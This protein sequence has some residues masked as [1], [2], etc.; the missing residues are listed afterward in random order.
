MVTALRHRGP[1]ETHVVDLGDAIFGHARL[2]VIDLETGTQPMST[3]DGRLWITYNGEIYNYVEIREELRNRGHVFRTESDT[4][5]VLASYLEW[6]GQCFSRLN[7]QWSLALWDRNSGS[8]LLSRDPFGIQPLYYTVY[9]GAVLFASE[10]KALFTHREIRRSLDPHGLAQ[11]FTFWCPLAPQTAFRD[12]YSLEPGCSLPVPSDRGRLSAT[13]LRPSR[14]F[15][16]SYGT[17]DRV[18]RASL[19]ENVDRF[20]AAFTDACRLRFRRS[21]VPVG[22]YLSGGID[23][24]VTTAVIASATPSPI[25]T[26]SVSFT[27]SEFDE[28]NYQRCVSDHLGTTHN[29]IRISAGDIGKVFPEVIRHA[30]QPILRTAPAPLFILSQLVHEK[31]YKVVV[32][33]EGS[34]EML[35]GYDIF[36]EAA[37]RR[38]VA[39]RPDSIACRGLLLQLYPWLRRSPSRVPAFA[40][41]FFARSE[42]LKDP[43]FSHRPRWS[44]TSALLRMLNSDFGAPDAGVVEEEFLSEMPLE[45]ERWHPLEQ[46]QYLEFH[47]ILSNYLLSAQG[48]R[49]LAAHSVEGRFPFLDPN[50]VRLAASLPPR[51]KLMG[52]REKYILKSAFSHLIPTEITDRPKQPYRAPDA[53]AF[54]ADGTSPE[55]FEEL[56]SPAAIT[57]A[58][59][60]NAAAVSA[61][62]K[63]CR[64][65]DGIGMSNTDNMRLVALASTMLLHEILV[66]DNTGACG[67]NGDRDI[68][69][70]RNA[71]STN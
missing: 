41:A 67:S 60:F 20:R 68:P 59:I 30:E 8:A 29:P 24:A 34:D 14:H 50:I 36:R 51:H 65:K 10:V 37:V 49:M 66:K 2:A 9:H 23:S 46:A 5:V 27:D 22:A 19:T 25:Q 61:L 53:R 18:R 7:G 12:V 15:V 16:V 71:L 28:S 35:A 3:P 58:G 32:T 43:A 54:V 31:G 63:K 11:A 13:M 48:D 17:D 52:L 6:G 38:L 40:Q 56:T 62:I 44:A 69:I 26:F 70:R 39:R 1:D 45:F 47:T 21:D 33:G 57:E 55:W 4:E 64:S 42:W